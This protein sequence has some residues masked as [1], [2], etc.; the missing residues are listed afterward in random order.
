[1]NKKLQHVSKDTTFDSQSNTNKH[2]N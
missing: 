1:M 2:K